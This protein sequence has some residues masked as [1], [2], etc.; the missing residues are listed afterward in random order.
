MDCSHG[1]RGS[2]QSWCLHLSYGLLLHLCPDGG[3]N[4]LG[5]QLF[6]IGCVSLTEME[7]LLSHSEYFFVYE[8]PT[9]LAEVGRLQVFPQLSLDD[10]LS[11]AKH[12]VNF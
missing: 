12:F 4:S 8:F 10:G 3:S 1:T 11:G 7:V 2:S 5:I 9:Y 6:C